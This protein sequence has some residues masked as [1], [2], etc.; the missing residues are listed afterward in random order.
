MRTLAGASVAGVQTDPMTPLKNVTVDTLASAL[1]A[2]LYPAGDVAAEEALEVWDEVLDG[3]APETHDE[4]QGFIG[5]IESSYFMFGDNR[6][7][8]ASS[9]ARVRAVIGEFMDPADADAAIETYRRTSAPMD[10]QAKLVRSE[11]NA[12]HT[13]GART[14][15][16][17]WRLF[18]AAAI[19]IMPVAIGLA[20]AAGGTGVILIAVAIGVFCVVGLGA[21]ILSS[22]FTAIRNEPVEY[23][24]YSE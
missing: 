7:D 19:V 14:I 23:T 10:E 9:F 2:H 22:V 15:R 11:W 17:I 4:V 1:R 21:G 13:N 24:V 5:A 6:H 18:W 12:A 8:R 16:T 20:I 3:K